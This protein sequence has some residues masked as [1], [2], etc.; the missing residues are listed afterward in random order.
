MI[1]I[2]LAVIVGF[3]AWTII[4]LGS[5]WVLTMTFDWYAKEQNQFM[6]AAY[7]EKGTFQASLSMLLMGI[8]RSVF[9]SFLVGYLTAL[10]AGENRR[11]TLILGVLLVATGI[12]FQAMAWNYLPI[13]YH[14]VFLLLLIPV[15]VAGGKVKKFTNLKADTTGE[16]AVPIEEES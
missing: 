16:I 11:S 14:L 10:I 2:I 4:W 12:Y 9:A 6:L 7:S 8:G 15:T 5:D 3:I 13:W 1:R